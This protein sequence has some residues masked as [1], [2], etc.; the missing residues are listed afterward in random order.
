[1][2]FTNAINANKVYRLLMK[3]RSVLW[4]KGLAGTTV[5]DATITNLF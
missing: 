1:M 4:G 3:Y 5:A 2:Q